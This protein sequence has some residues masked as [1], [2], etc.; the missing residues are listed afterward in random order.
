MGDLCDSDTEKYSY[1]MS[2]F[3]L[4]C[5]VQKRYR[6]ARRMKPYSADG[7]VLLYGIVFIGCR[8]AKCF[9]VNGRVK[10]NIT[11]LLSYENGQCKRA[12]VMFSLCW[13][14]IDLIQKESYALV[15]MFRSYIIYNHS[16]KSTKLHQIE[17]LL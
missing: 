14:N 11:I 13:T 6:N 9:S 16:P 5:I 3:K 15:F 17:I 1:F 12:S 4:Y 2:P 7:I 8:K 10:R